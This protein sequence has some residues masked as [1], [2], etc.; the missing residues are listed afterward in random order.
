MKYDCDQIK[1]IEALGNTLVIAGAGSGKTSTIIG[2]VD[3]LIKNNLYKRDEIL[4][5]SFTNESVNSIK[6]KLKHKVDVSTFHKLALNILKDNITE[7][8]NDYD[9]K[10]IIREYLLSYAT[11][12]KKTKVIYNR[13]LKNSNLDELVNLIFSFI[14]I[15]KSNYSNID[16]LFNLYNKSIFTNKYY[17]K[18]ILDIYIVYLRELESSNKH[19]F[20]DLIIN[21]T[22]LINENK[23][24]L[25][26]KFVIID[27]FQDSSLI[28]FNLVKAIINKTNGN[29]FVVGDDYQSIYRFSGCDLGLFINFKS[30]LKDANTIF[31]NNNYRNN[32]SLID[33]ANNFIMKNK[34]QIKK[35][36]FCHKDSFKPI[37]IVFY[38]DRQK[39]LEKLLTKINGNV[40]ILGRNNI[41]KD[42]FNVIE[43]KNIRFLTV[44]KSKGLEEDNVIIINLYN[45]RLGF[46]SLIKNHQI[47]NKILTNDY[48]I[49]EEE[50]RLFYVA[51]TR[52]KNNVYLLTPVNNYSVFIRELIWNYQEKIEII[53]ID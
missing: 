44:H 37:K 50:R 21:A 11:H 18:L 12:N 35:K 16:T 41:D 39:S 30:Y 9:L 1:A 33:I 36:T 28:R 20:N 7:I 19:D 24:T 26:Y 48:I 23:V 46:P 43:N 29:L 47:L 31:L 25:K 2:K 13:L 8:S 32:Q 6:E 52:S 34:H 15:Y 51:L 5:I 42:N 27:E 22:K 14:N 38:K 40:L 4:I 17:F 10:Y 45:S 53:N 3:Y 49:H